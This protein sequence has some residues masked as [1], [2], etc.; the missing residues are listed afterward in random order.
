MCTTVIQSTSQ[1]AIKNRNISN[2]G[3][4]MTDVTFP[5][6][7]PSIICMEVSDSNSQWFTLGLKFHNDA[8]NLRKILEETI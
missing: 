1:A 6:F 8:W 4:C 7:F 3:F 2:Y 5:V